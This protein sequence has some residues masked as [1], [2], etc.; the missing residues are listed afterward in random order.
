[1]VVG[2]VGVQLLLA[3]LFLLAELTHQTL[4]FSVDPNEVDLE[5]ALLR[6]LILAQGA[7]ELFPLVDC[8]CVTGQGSVGG[9]LVAAQLA[10]VAQILVRNLQVVA[11]Q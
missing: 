3:P 11:E 9:G 5:V 7:R 4:N 8:S 6:G 10:L 1:V 2:H